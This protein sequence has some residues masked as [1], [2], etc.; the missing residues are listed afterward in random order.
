VQTKRLLLKI[1]TL[2]Y[3]SIHHNLGSQNPQDSNL[4]RKNYE[5]NHFSSRT[6]LEVLRYLR[7]TLIEAL[8]YYQ[9]YIIEMN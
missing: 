4:V 1:Q 9:I 3:T 5:N 8:Q 7:G 6:K 2:Q